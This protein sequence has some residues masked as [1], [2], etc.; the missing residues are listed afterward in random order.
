M[1]N[2]SSLTKN[3]I[4]SSSTFLESESNSSVSIPEK[5]LKNVKKKSKILLNFRKNIHFNTNHY[6]ILNVSS[7]DYSILVCVLNDILRMLSSLHNVSQLIPK[8]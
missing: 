6:V 5:E 7:F 8:K 4:T 3:S 2:V 1:I